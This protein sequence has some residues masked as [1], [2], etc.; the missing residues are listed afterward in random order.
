MRARI[1]LPYEPAPTVAAVAT[2]PTRA[3]PPRS[4]AIAADSIKSTTGARVLGQP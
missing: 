4:I 3:K 2:T 1:V